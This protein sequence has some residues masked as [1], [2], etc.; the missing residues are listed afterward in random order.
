MSRRSDVKKIREIIRIKHNNPKLSINQIHKSTG[1]SRS[2]ISDL[3]HRYHESGVTFEMI[4]TMND[5]ALEA[6]IYPNSKVTKSE[7]PEPDCAYIDKELRK[8]GVNLTLLWYEYKQMHPD[9]L[10]YTQFCERYRNYVGARKITQHIE[11][12]AG[13]KMFVD[14]AG[15]MM[16]ITDIDT[17]EIQDVVLFVTT[18]GTSG[19][20]Y[21]EA[22]PS[23]EKQYWIKGH[24]HAFEHYK[25]IP[26]ILVPDNDKSAVT[27][28]NNTEPIINTTYKEMAEHYGCVIIP[29]RIRKPRDK[30]Q[31]E[32]AVGWITTW[33]NGRLR[34]HKF[35]SLYELNSMIKLLLSE[36]VQQPYQKRSGSRLSLF[37]E[38]DQP[39]LKPLPKE[40]YTYGEWLKAKVNMDYHIQVEKQYYSVPYTYAHE[41]VDVRLSDSNVMIFHKGIRLCIHQRSY[42]KKLYQYKTL[43]EHMPD[44]HKTYVNSSKTNF[45]KWA[46]SIGVETEILMASLFKQRTIEE[47]AYR[48]CLAMKRLVTEYGKDR[49]ENACMLANKIQSSTY[50]YVSRILSQSLDLQ[51]NEEKVIIHKNIRG[52][53]FYKEKEGEVIV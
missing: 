33:I 6:L 52:S 34:N 27:K 42:G 3:L 11:L 13:E 46:K 48:Q 40:R 44:N 17:G 19:Y 51:Q 1:I 7:R 50:H 24:I 39:A 12:K 21:V 30:G 2:A 43:I 20:P 37:K 10:Q 18:L 25:G 41:Y 15:D 31:V 53:Q 4:Q 35:F 29:A 8:P 32:S 28:A 22:F 38:L 14:W 23:K 45:M 36:L 49:V 16:R 5:D 47:Q 9:G 26:I